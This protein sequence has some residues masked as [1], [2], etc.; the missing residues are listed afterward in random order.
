MC[1]WGGGGGWLTN[2]DG[3]SF[4]GHQLKILTPSIILLGFFCKSRKT[5]LKPYFENKLLEAYSKIG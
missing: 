5:K 3:K 4:T 1:V 2:V